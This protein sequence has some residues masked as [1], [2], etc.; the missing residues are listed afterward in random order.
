LGSAYLCSRSGRVRNGNRPW[1]GD[2]KLEPPMPNGDPHV[3]LRLMLSTGEGGKLQQRRVALRNAVALCWLPAAVR[4]GLRLDARGRVEQDGAR[5]VHEDGDPT[6]NAASNLRVVPGGQSRAA[7]R[8]RRAEQREGGEG[9]QREAGGWGGEGWDEG[10]ER[11][12]GGQRGTDPEALPP[13]PRRR[14]RSPST[15]SRSPAAAAAGAALQ[16]GGGWRA[17][18][19]GQRELLRGRER[20]GGRQRQPDMAA[21]PVTD[22]G[23]GSN[24]QGPTAVRAAGSGGAGRMAS[25]GGPGGA[26][27]A[28][29]AAAAAV[30]AVG[31]TPSEAVRAARLAATAGAGQAAGLQWVSGFDS[32]GQEG[33]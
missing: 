14:Q 22:L 16:G 3:Y 25:M 15:P 6:N 27:A 21:D 9:W 24:A 30:G 10:E 7:A 26:A 31:Q 5:V 20:G 8:R 11:E 17:P 2:C 12:E 29:A 13:P 4:H 28:A 18:G 23:G 32:R 1:Q 19:V 33:A